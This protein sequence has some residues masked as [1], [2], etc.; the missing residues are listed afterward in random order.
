MIDRKILLDERL[1]EITVDRLCHQLIEKHDQFTD[2]VIIGVQP[3]GIFLSGRICT[4]LSYI[5]E[6]KEIQHGKLDITFYRDD[7]RRTEE[8]VT[9]AATEMD[10]VV[11]G[12]RVVLV[13]DVLYTGRTIRSALDAI[14]AFGRPREVEL[15]CLVDRKFSRQLPIQADYIGANVDALNSQ[16][17]KVEWKETDGQDQVI[18][19]TPQR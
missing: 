12:K 6:G 7:F 2:T 4:R 10:F 3:R 18:L 1:F 8:I 9:P 11:E 19:F 15:L 17:V 5:L 13:D 14:L 16:K